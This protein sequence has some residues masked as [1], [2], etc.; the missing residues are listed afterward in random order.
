MGEGNAR[1]SGSHTARAAGPRVRRPEPAL[2]NDSLRWRAASNAKGGR[3]ESVCVSHRLEQRLR[4]RKED[5]A[6]PGIARPADC[7]ARARPRHDRWKNQRPFGGRSRRSVASAA[8][9]HRRSLSL[10]KKRKTPAAVTSRP[11]TNLFFFLF[12]FFSHL[13]TP[14]LLPL[15]LPFPSSSS[16]LLRLLRFVAYAALCLGLHWS[17]GAPTT[18]PRVSST[19]AYDDL[20]TIGMRAPVRL[21]SGCAAGLR[22]SGWCSSVEVGPVLLARSLSSVTRSARAA[23]LGTA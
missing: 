20:A 15:L 3:V 16:S 9:H 13:P 22:R 19:M 23:G 11:P 17:P 18:A 10:R 5:D 4:W 14:P 2:T 7:P 6:V 21:G 1:R 12:F 8:R